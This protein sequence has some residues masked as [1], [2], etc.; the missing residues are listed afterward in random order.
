MATL[1]LYKQRKPH[2]I[3]VED[4]GEPRELLIP[5]SY[6]V[7]EIERILELQVRIDELAKKEASGEKEEARKQI[8][9]FWDAIFEQLLV[10]FERYQ[11]DMT[12]E[13]LKRLLTRDEAQEIIVFHTK[14]QLNKAGGEQGGEGKK[15]QAKKK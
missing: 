2:T 11:P 14:E 12:L 15:K 1:D 6:T 5:N 13:E 9:T 3:V 8:D 4:K 10:L 7:E